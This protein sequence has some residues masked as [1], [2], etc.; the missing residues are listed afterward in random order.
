[1]HL[2][3]LPVK[4]SEV[5]FIDFHTHFASNETDVLSVLNIDLGAG[6]NWR[7]E[8]KACSVGIHPWNIRK[9]DIVSQFLRL[10]DACKQQNVIAIG[11][12]GLDKMQGPPLEFQSRVFEQQVEM[13]DFYGKPLIVHCV[14][15]YYELLSVRKK[16]KP[17][18]PFVV[19]G[20]NKNV[21]VLA[22]LVNNG[23]FI[24]MGTSIIHPAAPSRKV[25]AEVPSDRLFLET[26]DKNTPI[27]GV[28]LAAAEILQ[29]D[30][31]R[32]KSTIHDNYLRISNPN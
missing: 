1:M 23:C 16:M 28:Y 17:S 22:D 30:L 3:P 32:L 26:D 7:P 13:A 19:H 9:N 5:P 4:Q 20:Y 25:L 10:E 18:V 31:D 24:S 21:Q 6:E 15:A 29:I 11:E 2:T 12:A 8:L 14:G 27:Q